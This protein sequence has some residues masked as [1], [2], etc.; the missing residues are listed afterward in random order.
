MKKLS[1]SNNVSSVC[2]NSALLSR[3]KESGPQ[4]IWS[5]VQI[6]FKTILTLL[7]AAIL[8][9]FPGG[10]FGQSAPSITYNGSTTVTLNKN[11]PMALL[12][13]TNT[14]DTAGHYSAS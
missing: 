3:I 5:P 7:Y 13:P 12:A 14:G 6:F 10:V 11:T 8:L 4:L 9:L 2:H 1:N